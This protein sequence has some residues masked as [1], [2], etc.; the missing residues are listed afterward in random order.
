MW[1]LF[2]PPPTLRIRCRPFGGRGSHSIQGDAADHDSASRYS[3]SIVA[4]KEDQMPTGTVTNPALA[5]QRLS[6]R[7]VVRTASGLGLAHAKGIMCAGNFTPSPEA[8]RL[9]RAPHTTRASGHGNCV[10]TARQEASF[11]HAAPHREREVRYAEMGCRCD[12]G[13]GVHHLLRRCGPRTCPS[14]ASVVV[15]RR[16]PHLV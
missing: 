3:S 16:W 14:R 8:A 9:T 13:G 11:R 6:A 5:Q 7:H 4:T 10:S 1:R 12:C 15:R 2:V